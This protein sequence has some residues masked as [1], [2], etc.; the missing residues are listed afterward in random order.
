ML[1]HQ[2]V[3]CIVT[4]LRIFSTHYQLLYFSPDQ[5]TSFSSNRRCL[6]TYLVFD[7]SILVL[8]FH[9]NFLW[10]KM[11]DTKLDKHKEEKL[12]C[13]QKLLVTKDL[14]QQSFLNSEKILCLK[15]ICRFRIPH[16]GGA[17]GHILNMDCPT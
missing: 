10:G 9:H 5:F 8:L 4:I 16:D 7:E 3:L 14:L 12:T 11:W 15:W 17:G 13:L 6:R 1:I 2:T